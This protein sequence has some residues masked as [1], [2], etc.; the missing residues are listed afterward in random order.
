MINIYASEA[1][2]D[3]VS[4]LLDWNLAPEVITSLMCVLIIIIITIILGAEAT[5]HRK[6]H[7]YKKTKGLLYLGEFGVTYFDNMVEDMM[8]PKFKG[9]G[10]YIMIIACYLFLAFIFG[11]TGLPSPMTNLAVPLTF[12]LSTFVLIHATSFKFKGLG[13]FKRYIDPNPVFLPINLISMW[14]PLISLTCRLF[15]NAISGWVLMS[16]VYYAL[17]SLSNMIFG[18]VMAAGLSSIWIAPLLAPALHCYF[19]LFAGFIQT[20]VFIFYSQIM[21]GREGPE[22]VEEK[23]SLEGGY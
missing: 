8:G 15:G 9:F 14:S 4:H 5:Y 19:D 16:I 18:G 17:E 12:G 22:D 2:T 1:A 21:I 6:H 10:G 13:Y 20:T 23:L 11:M 3:R 7:P